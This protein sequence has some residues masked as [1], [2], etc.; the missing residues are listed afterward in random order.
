M[1]IAAVVFLATFIQGSAGFGL[2]LVAMPVLVH[3]LGVPVASPL[4]GLIG[5]TA[6]VILVL[7]YRSAVEWPTVLQMLAAAFC[8]IPIGVYLLRY[9]DS[10]W[11]P[12]LLGMLILLYALYA[13]LT[14]RLPTLA[15]P[16]WIFFFGAFSGLLT[17]AFATG[18]PPVVILGN[19]R[20]WTGPRFKSNL[21][22]FFLFS[23]LFLLAAHAINRGF[24]TVVWRNYLFALPA[25]VLGLLAGFAVDPY[26][27][28]ERFRVWTLL[29]LLGLGLSLVIA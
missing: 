12:R 8:T 21:Q 13:L 28:P 14:P 10:P 3:F 16:G 19:C 24:T 11:A 22:A 9:A 15:H 27:N 20:G 2:A 7:R 25:I 4:M 26:L 29:L 6:G 18:G 5:Q 17:G 23:G 1:I